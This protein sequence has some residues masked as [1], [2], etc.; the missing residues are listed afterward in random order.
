MAFKALC[1][2]NDAAIQLT[3][4]QSG[5]GF[6]RVRRFQRPR[7]VAYTLGLL[8]LAPVTTF[9]LELG[10]ASIRSALGQS[11]LVEIPYR[12]AADERLTPTC[13]QLVPAAGGT[14][15]LPTYA[16]VSRI[17]VSSTHIEI[18]DSKSV[19]EPLIG[20]TI[21]VH[22]DTTP[23]FVRSYRLFVDPPAR[24]PA[25]HSNATAVAAAPKQ[26]S[27]APTAGTQRTNPSPRARGH[28]GGNVTQGQTYRVARG[29]TLSG[30]AAR[31]AERPGTIRETMDA[32]FAANPEAFIRGN[33]DLIEEGRSITIPIMSPSTATASVTSLPAPLP[34]ARGAELPTAAPVPAVDPIPAPPSAAQPVRPE[35]ATSVETPVA[36][37]P[38]L[39]DV[40][41]VA[42]PSAAPVPAPTRTGVAASTQN[43]GTTG[44]FTAWVIALLALGVVIVLSASLAF[45]HRRRKPQAAAQ[46]GEKTRTSLPRPPIELVAGIEVVE[47]RPA[48]APMDD[49]TA[50][51]R[52]AKVEPMADS[53]AV[54]PPNLNDL[55][56]TIGPTDSVDLDV[57]TP[58]VADE[59]VDWSVDATGTAAINDAA[60]GDETVEEDAATV[61]MP[62]IDTTLTRGEES[63]RREVD[64][65][66]RAVD[67]E[68]M[69]LTLTELDMLR[70]DYEA[71]HTLTQQSS[72]ALRN[73]VADLNATKAARAAAGETSEFESPH[74]AQAETTDAAADATTARI[75]RK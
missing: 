73:A 31:V 25:I 65:S 45:V 35:N 42:A 63:P 51:M 43:L 56:L 52:S 10:E 9:A 55:A 13:V 66:K 72:Q 71:E 22:C 39:A 34:A 12:L 21:D 3:A 37:E 75:R 47:R 1:P 18:F 53:G 46:T 26:T 38:L 6:G 60:V 68:Q 8:L 4:N 41:A 54:S 40:T 11:L 30:I 27:S 20:L 16:S 62:D 23:R 48:D 64:R 50:S 24:T 7:V 14:D 17:T 58:L 59:R 19:R 57:G 44:R 15:G 70:Q 36:I 2:F 32:I 29:D 67:D 61:R 5:Q 28:T 33:R 69:T 74:Q 49:E